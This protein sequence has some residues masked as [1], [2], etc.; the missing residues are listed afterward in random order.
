MRPQPRFLVERGGIRPRP[1]GVARAG[2]KARRK[3]QDMNIIGE[4]I[5]KVSLIRPICGRFVKT[6][7]DVWQAGKAGYKAAREVRVPAPVSAPVPVPASIPPVPAYLRTPVRVGQIWADGDPT[8]N[9][10]LL[11]Q[12]INGAYAVCKSSRTGHNVCIRLDRFTPNTRGYYLV[13]GD[14]VA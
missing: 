8:S 7:N 10:R 13:G 12:S 4:V 5:P 1:D 14:W 9:R 6:V 2:V 3:R 11:V